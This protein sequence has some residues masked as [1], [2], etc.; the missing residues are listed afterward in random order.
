MFGLLGVKSAR[1]VAGT[2]LRVWPTVREPDELNRE[3]ERED[4]SFQACKCKPR[5]LLTS[6]VQE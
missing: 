4:E 2:D 5:T 1:I 3:R 6:L